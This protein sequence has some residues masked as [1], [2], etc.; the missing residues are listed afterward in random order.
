[1]I[2]RSPD[3]V[4][5]E[6]QNR[7]LLEGSLLVEPSPY[8]KDVVFLSTPHRGSRLADFG[9][10]RLFSRLVRSP[11]NLVA[12]AGDLFADDPAMDA[13]RRIS[14]SRSSVGNMSPDSEFIQLLASLPIAPGISAHS[15]IGVR[16]G[17]IEEGS[18]GVVS[19]QS[20]H[21]EDV[22]SELVV[23][24]GHSSQS[25]PVVVEEIRR[26]LIEHLGDRVLD[27][28]TVSRESLSAVP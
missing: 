22:D 25:H 4:E 26:I 5:L 16:K 11:A 28:E 13:Q 15:I 9:L 23:E 17:P 3:E 6:P 1:M 10:A 20:A 7:K 18:D 2:D 12:A 27:E 21:L 8:V 14:K 24:S 19:Y